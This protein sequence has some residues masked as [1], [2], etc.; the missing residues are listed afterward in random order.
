MIYLSKGIARTN[1]I[2]TSIIVARGDREVQLEGL[3]AELWLRGR[4]GFAEMINPFEKDA[5]Q[6]LENSELIEC[7]PKHTKDAQYYILSRCVCCTARV[8][9]LRAPLSREEKNI[10]VW[11]NKA[12]LRLSTAELIY[13]VENDVK[14]K[15]ELLYEHNRQ[16]LV[17]RIYT[18]NTISDNIL[19]NQMKYAKCRDRVINM[20]INLLKKKRIVIL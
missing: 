12:G 5:L 3:E 11:L 20:L 1:S 13:L 10:I 18:T 4:F 2:N 6:K 9:L 8:N 14:P 7:E 16:A 15:S 19:E 17:E